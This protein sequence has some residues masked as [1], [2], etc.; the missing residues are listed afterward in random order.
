[1]IIDAPYVMSPTEITWGYLPGG[2]G[3]V[4]KARRPVADP[5][6]ALEDAIRPALR[7]P[8]CG[9]AFSGGRDSSFVLAV[10]T[11]L[12]RRE[13][14]PDP[15]PITRRFPEVPETDETDWQELV[16]RHL[17]LTDWQRLAF[18]DELDIVGPFAAP[19]LREFGVMWPA[20]FASDLPMF[21]V[22]AGGSLIDGEG[23]D[24]VLG[25]EGFRVEP[26][27]RLIHRPRALNRWRL[28]Q[29][30]AAIAPKALRLKRAR[31]S[32]VPIGMEWLRP[33]PWAEFVDTVAASLAEEP[34]PLDAALR[35]IPRQRA[36]TEA[37]R[38]TA[39]LAARHDVAVDSPLIA[40]G[41]VAALAADE[42]WLGHGDRTATLRRLAADL[43]PDQVLTR[44]T[45]GNFTI[46]YLGAPTRS[47][48]REWD[49][50]GLDDNIVDVDRLRELWLGDSPPA[51]TASL[52]QAAWLA[53]PS[54]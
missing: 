25:D 41:F 7:R 33:E 15:L 10:A 40:P 27:A 14:H 2:D 19:L 12:A 48:V 29:A 28:R 42:G 52:V 1:M 35:R 11:R 36:Q 4:P 17:A 39:A 31:R 26:L 23:G 20:S 22:V 18:T 51:P 44:R 53:C 45:K 54:R 50:T 13:G 49:G 3:A 6:T 34:L 32:L 46:A 9:V 30:L 8:P 5:M 43:L 37:A 21:D 24:D 38:T 16:V 47:F